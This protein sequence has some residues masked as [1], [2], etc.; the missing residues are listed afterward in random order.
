MRVLATS[1]SWLVVCALSVGVGSSQIRE[2]RAP[3]V[4]DRWLRGYA[5]GQVTLDGLARQAGRTA[6]IYRG[7]LPGPTPLSMTHAE[8]FPPI[9]AMSLR[10]EPAHA[11]GVLIRLAGLG[12]V[13]EDVLARSRHARL[14]ELAR[15]ALEAAKDPAVSVELMAVATGE[16]T[17]KRVSW[18]GVDTERQ[19][20]VD[21]AVA[22]RCLAG[23]GRKVMRPIA[24]AGLAAEDP[25]IRL[26]AVDAVGHLGGA[27]A[28]RAL[29]ERL[30]EEGNTVVAGALARRLVAILR[31]GLASGELSPSPRDM[32]AMVDAGIAAMGRLDWRVDFQLV[33]LFELL[34]TPRVMPS[35]IEVLERPIAIE[36]PWAQRSG[37]LLQQA[38]ADLAASL[39]GAMH[40]TGR[41][42]RMFWE[43]H[44]DEVL[45][46]TGRAVRLDPSWRRDPQP[47]SRRTRVQ[48]FGVR[49]T[50][51][52]V[53]FVL[54]V[55]GSMQ[56]QMFVRG[57]LRTRGGGQPRTE[58]RLA[59]AR[60]E[61]W[62]TIQAL[63]ADTYFN[64]VKFS[65]RASLWRRSLVRNSPE[66]R[67][68][69][70][71]WLAELRAAGGTNLHAALHFALRENDRGVTS[72]SSVLAEEIFVLSDGAPS[73]GAVVEDG[74]LLDWVDA[75]NARARARMHCIYIGSGKSDL[76][77]RV[78][79]AHSGRYV[80]P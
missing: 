48:Y 8:A 46:R 17:L 77:E 15:S 6:P 40:G 24:V 73:V 13:V 74:P 37:G 5:S 69:L 51:K 79:R 67:S 20:V 72:A 3:F 43:D 30:A 9:A 58:M 10:A 18:T 32:E 71:A 41:D 14:R 36:G 39:S 23:G 29:G 11:V 68:A 61:L 35:L 38:A 59:V 28:L 63:P 26:S 45:S 65:E 53:V 21:R 47:D 52:R 1:V 27:D 75:A 55:S 78:A 42:W 33:A 70:R 80:A 4:L 25:L 7:L 22:I 76:L 56:E 49:V 12:S 50:G 44:A 2:E 66:A 57:G 54:D 64:V 34:R 19:S 16:S 60:R 31:A 62:R